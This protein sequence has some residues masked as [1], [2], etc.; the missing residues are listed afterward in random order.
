VKT[1]LEIVWCPNGTA[2]LNFW[3]DVGGKDIC[4]QINTGGRLID[5]NGDGEEITFNEFISRVELIVK[6]FTV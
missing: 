1:K 2:F 6:P 3:D 4:C 5:E